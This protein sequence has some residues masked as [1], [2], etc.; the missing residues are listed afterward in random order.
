MYVKYIYI[1]NKVKSSQLI[2]QITTN[3]PNRA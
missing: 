1:A 3:L 2:G